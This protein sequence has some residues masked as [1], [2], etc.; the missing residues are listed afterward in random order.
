MEGIG[1]GGLPTMQ[2]LADEF[3]VGRNM[4]YRLA[5]AGLGGDGMLMRKKGSGITAYPS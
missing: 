3:N 2:S 5:M 4:P 1:S